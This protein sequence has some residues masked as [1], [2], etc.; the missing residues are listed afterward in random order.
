[1]LFSHW[2]EDTLLGIDRLT[3]GSVILVGSERGAWLSL[4]AAQLIASREEV[5]RNLAAK[6]L[7]AN[8]ALQTT[9]RSKLHSL[10]MYDIGCIGMRS[11]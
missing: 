6:E 3:E 2:I 9:F 10:S 5:N 8:S 4:L 11:V 7:T 1:M